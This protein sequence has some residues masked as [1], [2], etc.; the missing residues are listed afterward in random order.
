MV[1]ICASWRY[2]RW[3]F[4]TCLPSFVS[5]CVATVYGRYHYIADVLA[6]IVVG[7][8]GFLAGNWLMQRKGAIPEPK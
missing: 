2:R 1:A 6:G 3:L 8:I 5:M 7:S 4:W